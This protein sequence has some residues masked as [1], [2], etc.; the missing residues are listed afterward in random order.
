MG[1]GGSFNFLLLT[2]Q[3]KKPGII[4]KLL[5]NTK[6]NFLWFALLLAA[7]MLSVV[8]PAV[9]NAQA[10]SASELIQEVNAYRAAN[11]LAAY[12]VDG[13]LMALAQSHSDYQASIQDCT[14]TRADGSQPAD[15]G[16]SAENIA[17]GNNLSVADAIYYQWADPLHTSTILGPTTGYVGAGVAFSGSTVYYTLAV[18]RLSGDFTYRPP[19]QAIQQDNP[20][21]GNPDVPEEP[22]VSYIQT[23]TPNE[24][25]SITHVVEYGETLIDIAEAY[26]I[27]LQELLSHNPS[28]S[29]TNPVYFEG[30]VLIIKPAFTPTPE[31]TATYTPR[32]PTR[33]PLPTRTPRPTYTVTA[34][35]TP[36]LT[37]TE[38]PEPLIKIPTI[39]DLGSSRPVIAYAFITI[40]AVG[41]VL[42]IATSFLPRKKG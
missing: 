34:I 35:R 9:V 8:S 40:S 42:L 37:P 5:M 29:P 14:H 24:D 22:L 26:G 28:L 16:I 10:G 15:Y 13:G 20:P 21:S 2:R 6:S 27:T 32:P 39:E 12:E 33:T 41:L 17:C 19:Q 38:T 1:S 7:L 4:A 3:G 31:M 11:G 23:S 25:G 18:K 30:D 36:T